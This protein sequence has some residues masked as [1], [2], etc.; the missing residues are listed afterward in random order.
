M[1][2][3]IY[4][5]LRSGGGFRRDAVTCFQRL[6]L[7]FHSEACIS[8]EVYSTIACLTRRSD[9][10]AIYSPAFDVLGGI[11]AVRISF[12]SAK[13]ATKRRLLADCALP[14]RFFVVLLCC[15]GNCNLIYGYFSSARPGRCFLNIA[16]RFFRKK[17]TTDQTSRR[18]PL[19]CHF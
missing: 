15:E 14:Y 1:L 13:L 12:R 11:I 10:E 2:P 7:G 6:R 5:F 9:T 4:I 16:S 3:N 17:E 19:H 18:L 8:P